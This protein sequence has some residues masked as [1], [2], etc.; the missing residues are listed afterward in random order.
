MLQAS[1]NY[2]R[3]SIFILPMQFVLLKIIKSVWRKFLQQ[4]F[5]CSKRLK[6]AIEGNISDTHHIDAPSIF[7]S[8]NICYIIM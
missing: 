2:T 7:E 5:S 4:V 1:R 8:S 6:K 3:Y